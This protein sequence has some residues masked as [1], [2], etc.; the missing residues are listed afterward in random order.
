MNR[1]ASAEE[2]LDGSRRDIRTKVK[3][4]EASVAS[5][6]DEG[7]FGKLYA[8]SFVLSIF[9]HWEDTIRPKIG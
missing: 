2:Y 7:L 4:S 3:C 9:S 6:S 1:S 8:K 5:F